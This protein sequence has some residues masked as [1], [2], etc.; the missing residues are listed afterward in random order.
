MFRGWGHSNQGGTLNTPG[1]LFVNRCSWAHC[2]AAV[3]QLLDLPRAHLLSAPEGQALD[4]ECGTHCR[5][6]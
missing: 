2:L 4:G 3:A 1:M 5:R 6:A